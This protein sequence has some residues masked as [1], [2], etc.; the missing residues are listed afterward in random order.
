[1]VGGTRG[2]FCVF[3][4]RDL[5]LNTLNVKTVQR[6]GHSSYERRTF[7]PSF[8]ARSVGSPDS[9]CRTSAITSDLSEK[10]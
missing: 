8:F 4:L 5:S 1:M 9:V 10:V 2:K 7:E 3:A 6:K